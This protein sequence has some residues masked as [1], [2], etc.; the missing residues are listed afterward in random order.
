MVLLRPS[1]EVLSVTLRPPFYPHRKNSNGNYDSIC[2]TCLAAIGSSKDE[3][4][5]RELEKDHSCADTFA[6]H[7]RT[8]KEQV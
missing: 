4:E 7:K 3:E 8:I 2:L 6:I 1:K 5:L